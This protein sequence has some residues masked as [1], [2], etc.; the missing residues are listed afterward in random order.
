MQWFSFDWRFAGFCLPPATYQA[1]T[2]LPVQGVHGLPVVAPSGDGLEQHLHHGQVAA[3]TGQ[4][5]RGVVVV[6]GLA[7]DVGPA[8]DEELNSA[9]VAGTTGLKTTNSISRNYNNKIGG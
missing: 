1:A 4:R 5:Q 2:G 3:G 8:G 9:Q 7:V 6:G